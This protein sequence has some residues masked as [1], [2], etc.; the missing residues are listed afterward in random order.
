M[1]GLP[2][3]VTASAIA[4]GTGATVTNNASVGGGGD[5]FNGNSTP[6]PASTCTALDAAAP[7]HCA[8]KP[9]AVNAPAA[10]MLAKS[11]P[12][13]AAAGGLGQYTATY[14]ITVTNN[15]G[16]AGAYTLEDTPASRQACRSMAGAS[17]PMA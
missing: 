6:A 16:V 7:G 12:A 11:A 8:S 10:M 9:T 5:P 14:T 1:I 2:V 17:R 3:N 4:G 15:G 13:I